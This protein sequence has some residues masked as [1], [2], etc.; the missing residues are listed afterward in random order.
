MTDKNESNDN[1][2]K[3]SCCSKKDGSVKEGIIY[4]LIP[5]IGCIAFIIG[6][7]LGVTVLMQ[8]FKPL[9]MSRY[10]F[11][12]LIL[13]SIGFA[14]LS[15]VLYLRKQ[16][17]LSKHGA[18]KK[19]KYLATMYGST[20]GI[21]LVLFLF[22]FPMLANVSFAGEDVSDITGSATLSMSV[23]I[24]CPGHAPLISNELKTIEGV[25]DVHY[26][27]P[28]N[29]D[30]TYDAVKTSK[31]NMLSLDVFDEY[32]ATVLE[33]SEAQVENTQSLLS[34]PV[35]S[36]GT[37]GGCGGSGKSAGS[38]GCSCGGCGA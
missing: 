5:H 25:Q 4:G 14:T 8:F 18:K 6:S 23:D 21:N 16:G 9:L 31:S 36:C 19:W 2:D 10:I 29:F 32:P 33:E 11:H 27:F 38:S 24:P 22:I 13:V 7:V 26:S 34:A 15:S 28:N 12:I 3:P 37:A 1:N 17:M 30:V 35:S 20:V